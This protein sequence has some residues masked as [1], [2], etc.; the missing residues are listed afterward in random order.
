MDRAPVS[1]PVCG[2]CGEP[3]GTDL[4]G[5]NHGYHDVCAESR[6]SGALATAEA[7]RRAAVDDQTVI[8]DTASAAAYMADVLARQPAEDTPAPVPTLR[9]RDLMS[10]GLRA[11]VD[12]CPACVPADGYPGFV[13]LCQ[14]HVTD[15]LFDRL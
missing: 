13:R 7:D 12:A 10:P 3:A 5:L 15:D 2:W 9:R 6:I 14:P 1:A 4:G 11:S 8:T